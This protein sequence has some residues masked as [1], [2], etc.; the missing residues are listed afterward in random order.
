MYMFK[1]K[2]NYKLLNLLMLAGIIYLIIN[3]FNWWGGIVHKVFSI[4]LP[5]IISFAIAYALY[6]CVRML[7]KK[8]VRSGLAKG[9]V[10]ITV[11]CVIVLLF[12][13][14]IPLV[15]DQLISLSKIIGDV[16][17]DVS[18]KF[19]INLGSFQNTINT[20]LD[21]LINNVGDYISKGA[22]QILSTSIG[23]L[24]KTIII[25]IVSIYFLIDMDKI[26][27]RAKLILK[28]INKRS[29]LYVKA[30][31]DELENYL[32]GLVIFMAIQLV[33]Y[34]LLFG[35][36]GHPNWLL[37][38]I[39]ASLTTVIPYFGGLATNIIAVILASV[40]SPKLFVATMIICLIF[41]NI[42]G[43]IISPKVYGK[44]NNINPVWSIFAVFA[45]GALYGFL[46]ILIAL[47][48]YLVL[49]CTY[50]FFKKDI[51]GKI[52]EIKN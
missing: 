44:T 1:N 19:S 16:I 50:K 41:P 39:L 3:T 38:G 14:T 13:I 40:V 49:R 2:L 22:I 8:G 15:Y 45:G 20:S 10:I 36:V 7:E 23:I 24:T 21:K 42:D 12:S 52:D 31:D 51:Y 34:S 33:E 35:I 6:P 37:L 25:T 27:N 17:N 32:L 43:Y 4:L 5:F 28:R 46:G 48:L 26:R 47:P 18:N 11:L 29:F 9:I 30:V